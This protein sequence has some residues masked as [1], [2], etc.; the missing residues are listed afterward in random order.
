MIMGYIM[1]W[2]KSGRLVV[3][4]RVPGFLELFVYLGA[5]IIAGRLSG[6][7]RTAYRHREGPLTR[8]ARLAVWVC[9]SGH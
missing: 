1:K 9:N 3:V 6:G 7:Y 4:G 8:Q 2:Q 5:V